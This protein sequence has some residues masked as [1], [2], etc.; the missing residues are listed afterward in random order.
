MKQTDAPGT[1]LGKGRIFVSQIGDLI[2]NCLFVKTLGI[3]VL[4]YFFRC[5]D[6]CIGTFSVVSPEC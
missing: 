6:F 4:Y 2:K 5:G 1:G 3:F